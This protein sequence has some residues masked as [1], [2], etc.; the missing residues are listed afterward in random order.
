MLFT[1]L[2]LLTK[3]SKNSS[4]NFFT[5][6]AVTGLPA[7]SRI[8]TN[9][10]STFALKFRDDNFTAS[11]LARSPTPISLANVLPAGEIIAFSII[12]SETSF[13]TPC[14][15]NDCTDLS[16]AFLARAFVEAPE[17]ALTAPR[18]AIPIGLRGTRNP[19]ASPTAR[20]ALPQPDSCIKSSTTPNPV[21]SFKP[22]LNSAR[23]I[24]ALDVAPQSILPTKSIKALSSLLGGGAGFS[25]GLSNI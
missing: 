21:K 8:A 24:V 3:V 2:L 13:D 1:C 16:A 7:L 19:T 12:P 20:P 11:S 18:V 6:L 22:G 25:S 15:N 14:F 4:E 17:S 23:P 9:A 5:V 10:A